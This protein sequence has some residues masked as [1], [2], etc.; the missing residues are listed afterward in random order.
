MSWTLEELKS[1]YY[2]SPS[3]EYGYFNYVQ[4]PIEMYVFVDPL[5]PEC[6]SLEPFL[7]KLQIEYG[8][9]FTIHPVVSGHLNSLNNDSFDRP[10]RIRDIWEK[11]AKRTGMS[12]DGD[13]W[14][15]NP[16]SS[17]WMASLAI[18]AAELQGKKAGKV[19]LRKIQENAF[20]Y[21]QNIADEEVL[22]NCAT[23][24]NLDVSE[25]ENDLFSTSAKKA[26][27]C[28]LKLTQEMEVDYIPSI[29][30][31]N[32]S[33]DEQGIKVSGLYPYEI[34]VDILE[35]ILKKPII[36]SEKPPLEGFLY[37]YG[38]VGTNEIAAVYDWTMAKTEREMKKLQLIQK[39]KRIPV[40]YGTFWKY[41]K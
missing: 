7:K 1:S 24:A 4:K 14:I 22:I 33:I 19:F 23:D 18:K 28:D 35:E 40:K 30:F 16:V 29:V 34:Y 9:F 21:K 15:E 11:T 37:Y 20:L 5:C 41:I 13:L 26:F 36:P 8:R 31:F 10:K 2:K 25:F 27:Q 32:Q 38:M 6:W 39:V 12:C 17:P 3:A